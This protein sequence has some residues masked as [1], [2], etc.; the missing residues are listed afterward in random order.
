MIVGGHAAI[1]DRARSERSRMS[2]SEDYETAVDERERF[3][4]S[5]GL[6]WDDP[7]EEAEEDEEDAD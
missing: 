4:Q 1:N 2:D 6:G 7:L 3:W 5:L